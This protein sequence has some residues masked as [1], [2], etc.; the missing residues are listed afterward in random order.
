M[1]TLRSA[2]ELCYKL[3]AFNLAEK[4]AEQHS[5]HSR[6]LSHTIS[7]M[8]S[9]PILHYDAP[10]QFEPLMPAEVQIG[11]LLERASD[12]TRAATALGSATAQAAQ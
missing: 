10:H 8:K 6:G 4:H 1:R 7:Q 11:P 2:E 3:G 12:L 9:Q 5:F